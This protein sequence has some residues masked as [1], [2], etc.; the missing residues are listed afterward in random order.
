MNIRALQNGPMLG[1]CV[2]LFLSPMVLAGGAG[3]V[4]QQAPGGEAAEPVTSADAGLDDS[5]KPS[6]EG[7]ARRVGGDLDARVVFERG[8]HRV[9]DCVIDTPLP[10]GYAP[11]TPPGAIDVKFYPS[12]RRAEVRSNLDP[13]GGGSAV[14]YPLFNHIQRR[15]IAMTSPVEFDYH[16]WD[17]GSGSDRPRGFTMSFLYRVP[18]NGD[19]GRDGPVRVLDTEPL[20][21]L[22]IGVRGRWGVET[23]REHVA[24]LRAWLASQNEWEEAGDVRL[25]GYNGPSVRRDRQWTEVQIPIVRRAVSKVGDEAASE[26]AESGSD[27]PVDA[28]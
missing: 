10:V 28:K 18:E 1:V 5:A 23:T 2:G 3:D 13:D 17:A 6:D 16:G 22:A 8:M 9:G 26:D 7:W 4:G 19:T 21:V 24:T 20:T 11:P 12:I 27:T 14:F 15:D 25:L